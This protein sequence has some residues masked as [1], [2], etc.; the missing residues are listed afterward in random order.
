MPANKNTK[1]LGS[2]DNVQRTR[3]STIN[4]ATASEPKSYTILP[5]QKNDVTMQELA[6]RFKAT[7]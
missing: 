6:N 2:A 5:G 7:K 4:K 3:M 1:I